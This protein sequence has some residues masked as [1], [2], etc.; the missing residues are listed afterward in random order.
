MRLIRGAGPEGLVGMTFQ[1]PLQFEDEPLSQE[2]VS[3]IRP[4]LGIYRRDILNY[5]EDNKLRYREDATNQ[6]LRYLRNKT[7]LQL[8]PLL[9]QEYNPRIKEL[10]CR[11]ASI[12][13]EEEKIWTQTMDEF[14]QKNIHRES[15]GSWSCPVSSIV[16]LPLG[17]QRRII[18]YCI[19]KKQG[20]LHQVGFEHI[21]SILGMLTK[22]GAVSSLELPGSLAVSVKSDKLVIHTKKKPA[23]RGTGKVSIQ[24]P[25]TTELPG[26]Q[27]QIKTRLCPLNTQWKKK[28]QSRNIPAT[29]AVMDADAVQ[30]PLIIRHWKAGDRMI[31]LGMQGTKKLQDIFVNRKIPV[32]DRG[33]IP[34]LCDRD[35]IIWVVGIQVSE[36]VKVTSSTRNLLVIELEK[37]NNED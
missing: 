31:P 18:R 25:G 12:L 8:V 32:D 15:S 22:Q 24:I 37:M 19:E 28:I 10:L 16:E 30:T 7:R 20:H 36:R 29:S 5:L 2:P 14:F 6:D 27:I 23:S 1:R 4:L 26:Y 13:M 9:E 11:T 35:N 34:V 3:V 21:E 17:L 33:Q